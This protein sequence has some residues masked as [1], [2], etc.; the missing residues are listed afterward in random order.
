MELGFTRIIRIYSDFE[1]DKISRK[2][3]RTQTQSRISN[4]KFMWFAWFAVIVFYLFIVNIA[5]A[6][7]PAQSA[8]Q[9]PAQE[10]YLVSFSDPSRLWGNGIE[11]VIE[12]AYRQYFKV[13]IIDGRVMNIRIPFA[14]NNDRDIMI[15]N[16]IYYIGDGKASPQMIWPAIEEILESKGFAEYIKALSSGREKVI[17]FD[18]PERKWSVQSDLFLIAQIKAGSYKG[19]PHRPYALT[20]G[21][22]AQE[23]DVYNYL[24]CIGYAGVDCSGFVWNILS[25]IGRQGGINLGEELRPVLGMPRNADP[26]RYAGTSF[27]N[28]RSQQIIP[29]ND[30]IRSLRPA[31]VLLFRDIDGVI[32]H[33]AII[34]SIDRT[35]GIIRYLQCNNVAPPNERGVHEAFI[36]FDPSNQTVSLKDPSLH[37]TKKRF[38]A[39]TG[40]D[41]PFAD[42]GERYRYRLNGGGRVVRIRAL[43][44]VIERLNKQ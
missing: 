33:S 3:D 25:H 16:K 40:E 18:I 24:Y 15:R 34:Q 36:Y 44:P 27:F 8:A 7:L 20:S 38:G 11:R 43:L 30:D 12:E 28:S 22:G 2:P 6:Q 29:V 39:F 17:I 1:K 5:S 42:D 10:N 26:A 4:G 41:I 14:M 23:S 31:D 35:R 19:L 32:V 9:L 37:W 13:K 21:K